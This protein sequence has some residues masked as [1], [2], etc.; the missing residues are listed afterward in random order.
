MSQLVLTAELAAKLGNFQQTVELVNEQ[1]EI[2][3]YC[4][5]PAKYRSSV[6][7]SPPACPFS[8]E[9]IAEAFLDRSEGITTVELLEKLR[10]L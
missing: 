2:L 3:A 7:L 9:E 6:D 5:P 4:L 1:G 8:D 10:K